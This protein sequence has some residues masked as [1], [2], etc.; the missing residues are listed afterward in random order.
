MLSTE[1]HKW[2]KVVGIKI[3][4]EHVDFCAKSLLFRTHHL[5]NSTTELILMCTPQLLK[6]AE[7]MQFLTQAT[8]CNLKRI[9]TWYFSLQNEALLLMTLTFQ[10]R[11]LKWSKGRLFFTYCHIAYWSYTTSRLIQKLLRKKTAFF[12]VYRFHV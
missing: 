4:F 10:I 9:T 2:F 3:S 11:P 12:L 1:N 7:K 8:F 5:W 6:E